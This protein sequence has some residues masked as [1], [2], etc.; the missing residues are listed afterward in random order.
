L[1]KRGIRPQG[2]GVRGGNRGII[3]TTDKGSI[4]L[5]C[6]PE[7][8]P[9]TMRVRPP[10]MIQR[11]TLDRGDIAQSRSSACSARRTP[12]RPREARSPRSQGS[13]ASARRACYNLLWPSQ[14]AVC[15]CAVSSRQR[16]VGSS[17][18]S[19]T[20]KLPAKPGQ[21]RMAK[22]GPAR[23]LG[24]FSRECMAKWAKAS[25]KCII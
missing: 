19:D 16:R 22:R 2:G 25:S 6:S 3:L 11:R 18:T 15:L 10:Q 14:V 21:N 24:F 20:T 7:P 5:T 9:A 8:D 1:H 4:V 12:S 17:P 13:S 23:M